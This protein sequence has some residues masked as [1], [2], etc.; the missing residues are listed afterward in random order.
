MPRKK[1]EPNIWQRPYAEWLKPSY[2]RDAGRVLYG[3]YDVFQSDAPEPATN[4]VLVRWID[5]LMAFDDREHHDAAP[6][7][8]V[9]E[10]DI[11]LPPIV[12]IWLADLAWR[13]GIKCDRGE[14]RCSLARALKSFKPSP[15]SGRPK[16]AAY[17]MPDHI[18]ELYIAND[19]VTDYLEEN[20][21]SVADAIAAIAC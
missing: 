4:P 7:V 9:L 18:A 10:S 11:E 21:G 17:D 5:A 20:G 6:L 3:E 1:P 12:G 2:N 13:H 8:A 14:L 16:G 19:Q 15:T